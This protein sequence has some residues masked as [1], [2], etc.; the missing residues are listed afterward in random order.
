MM[1]IVE[2]NDRYAAKVA[3][4]WN[5]SNSSWGNRETEMTEQDVIAAESKV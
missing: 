4:M 3:V 1:K 2:Y 5:K